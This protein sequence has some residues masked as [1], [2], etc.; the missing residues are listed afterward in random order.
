[1]G[2]GELKLM[3][4]L[5]QYKVVIGILAV[6]GIELTPIKI[7]PIKS[8]G[9]LFGKW[10]GI[11]SLGKQI[12][13][14]DEKVDENEKDRIRY[15]ILQFSSSLRSGKQKTENDYTHIEELYQKYH[16]KLHANSYISSEMDYIRSCKN[17][18]TQ[19]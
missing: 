15:E 12:T 14:V 19:K 11:D 16:E 1:M 2:I 18:N 9:K 17:N 3:T 13:K 6:I 5:N 8:L 7:N 4:F 10:I